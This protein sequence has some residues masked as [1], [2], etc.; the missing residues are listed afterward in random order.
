VAGALQVLLS[1]L[2]MQPIAHYIGELDRIVKIQS[3]R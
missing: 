2:P 3:R 1:L